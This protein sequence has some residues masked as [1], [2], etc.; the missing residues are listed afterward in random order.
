[1]IDRAKNSH[2]RKFRGG[3]NSKREKIHKLSR[4]SLNFEISLPDAP[5]TQLTT[6]SYYF[7]TFVFNFY[8]ETLLLRKYRC[9]WDSIRE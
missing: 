5:Y 2:E 1:M 9:K 4:D 7:S 8:R 3:K 6:T